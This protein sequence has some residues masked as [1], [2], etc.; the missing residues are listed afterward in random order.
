MSYGL[1]VSNHHLTSISSSSKFFVAQ[2]FWLQNAFR[3][4]TSMLY[5]FLLVTVIDGTV[6]I[7]WNTG[8]YTYEACSQW[9]THNTYCTPF[10]IG[11]Y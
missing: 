7:D 6:L 1:P 3:V 5:L 10:T 8:Y 2:I 11:K 4:S 9:E